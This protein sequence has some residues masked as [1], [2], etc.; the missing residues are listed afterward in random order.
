MRMA[1]GL[2]SIARA[3]KPARRD[4][5]MLQRVIVGVDAREGRA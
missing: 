5:S 3:F 2:L 1:G 4:I